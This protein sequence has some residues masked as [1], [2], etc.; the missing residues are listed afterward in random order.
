MTENK[1][2][3]DGKGNSHG[4]TGPTQVLVDDRKE[5]WYRG[6]LHRKDGPA[7]IYSDGMECWYRHG[8]LHR[9]DG[10]AV[11]YANGGEFWW[12][13]GERHREDGPAVKLKCGFEIWYLHDKLHCL[14]GP[15]TINKC[16]RSHKNGEC[17]NV[18]IPESIGEVYWVHNFMLSQSTYYRFVDIVHHELLVPPGRFLEASINGRLNL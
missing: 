17:T 16:G 12:L 4:T 14:C 7:R 13:N 11:V 3:T 9:K 15:A 8:K 2:L 10:P 5:W 6:K 1:Q 18:H